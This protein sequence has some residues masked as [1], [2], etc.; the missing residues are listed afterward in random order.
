V[1]KINWFSPLPPVRSGIAHYAMQVLPVLAGCHEVVLWTDQD[2]VAPE[3]HRIARIARF[4]PA[5]PPWRELNNG[6]I[7][8]YHLGNHPDFHG[9]IWRV[10]AQQPGIVVLHDLCLQDFFFMLL[11]HSGRD[12]AGYL[13]AMERWYG[14]EGRHVAEALCAGGISVGSMALKF[15]LTREAVGGALGV[16][17]HS[18]RALEEFNERPACPIAALD[19]PYAA[20]AESH[21]RAWVAAR[22]AAPGPPYRLVVFG[23]L[24]RNRR[25]GALLEALAAIGEREQ[26]RLDICGQLWDDG[27][28][29]TQID[30]L[31]LNS[32]VN[33][34]GFLPDGQVEPKLATSHLAINLRYPSMGEASLSQLQF[35]DY[36]L[37]TLVTRTG[38]YAS[39]P[40]DAV[41]F[42]RPECEV[43]DI[44]AQ[45][46]AFL[47]DPGAFRAMGERGRR[48]LTNHDPQRY[49]DAL[50][51][52]AAEALRLS[53]RV[54]A[55]ALA[56]RVGQDLTGW[57]HPDVGPYV[58]ERASKE[59]FALLDG[60]DSGDG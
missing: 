46:R 58:L 56:R 19:F 37:P 38:W 59:V 14:Q 33:L 27:Q 57:L 15:P 10:S 13:A 1:L 49:V 41:A 5:S 9:G 36:G 29:R 17:T 42:V 26:F 25:L 50:A 43:T 18:G 23:Y 45:L 21:Y 54:S 2:Q 24:G 51:R 30:R 34:H 44:Q 12:R 20:A 31:G 35:W 48:Y 39:L 28:V 11:A 52:F 40:E 8:I 47:A 32:L 53:P 7:S 55:L 16:V 6:A 60:P 22:S 4:D 3:A